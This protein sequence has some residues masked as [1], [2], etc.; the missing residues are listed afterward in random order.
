MS[1]GEAIDKPPALSDAELRETIDTMG[2]LMASV[3]N[4]VDDQGRILD[5]LIQ[6]AAETR[7]AAFAAHQA[8]DWER[9]GQAVTEHIGQA[10]QPALARLAQAD[11]HLEEIRKVVEKTEGLLETAWRRED[12]I[13]AGRTRFWQRRTPY[14]VAAALVLGMGLMLLGNHVLSHIDLV[15]RLA[16]GRIGVANEDQARGCF[17]VEW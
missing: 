17:F 1:G 14:I 13:R 16:G 15:C 9:N 11:R 2:L 6:T 7:A 12:Q 4:R 3:S 8:T 5:K 10:I